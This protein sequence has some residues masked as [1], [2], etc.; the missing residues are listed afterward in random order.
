MFHIFKQF[1]SVLQ[2]D[3]ALGLKEAGLAKTIKA[4]TPVQK[5]GIETRAKVI[6]AA[7]ALFIEKGYFNTHA[8][9]IAARA[10]VATGTFY[11]YFNDKKEVLLEVIRQFY[12]EA[13]GKA[14]AVLDADMLRSGNG[15]MIIHTLIRTL[16]ETHASQS[17]LHRALFPLIFLVEDG[18]AISR[19]EEREVIDTIASYFQNHR[20]LL[21][22]ANMRA[23]AEMAF[24]TSDEIIHRILFWGSEA[25]GPELLRE[26]EDMLY[27]YLM[28]PPANASVDP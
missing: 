27:R 28:R 5:R 1:F 3:E 21:R 10:G 11:S 26:L 17:D 22:V 23:A 15:R 7:K 8:L 14:L 19:Q 20:H 18:L 25:D 16:Y 24:K 6:G 2:V 9:E 12:R 13:L 4:R